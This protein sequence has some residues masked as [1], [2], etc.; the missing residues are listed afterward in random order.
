[1]MNILAPTGNSWI[2]CKNEGETRTKRI[3]F[4]FRETYTALHFKKGI[5]KYYLAAVE[6][7]LNLVYCIYL[8]KCYDFW[9]Q[10]FTSYNF[11]FILLFLHN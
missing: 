8:V 11:E 10:Q 5:S 4:A 6:I 3:I 1:M 2:Y 7:Q 9:E